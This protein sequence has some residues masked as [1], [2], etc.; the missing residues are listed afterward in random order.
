MINV[1]V[2]ST[3]LVTLS[4][5][6]WLRFTIIPPKMDTMKGLWTPS[7]CPNIGAWRFYGS[8]ARSRLKENG[9]LP[10]AK[11]GNKLDWTHLSHRGVPMVST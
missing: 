1:M 6:L 5:L 10:V 3:H 4:S 2:M 9:F 7:S 8:F 11:Q